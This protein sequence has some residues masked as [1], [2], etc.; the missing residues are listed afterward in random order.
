MNRRLQRGAQVGLLLLAAATPWCEAGALQRLRDGLERRGVE[1]GDWDLDLRG[2][3]LQALAATVQ[4]R[5]LHAAAV[6]VALAGTH[7]RVDVHALSI[8]RAHASDEDEPPP[9]PAPG[10]GAAAT[11]SRDRFRLRPLGLPIE[12]WI[13]DAVAIEAGDGVL[14]LHDV[15][16]DVDAQGWPALSARGDV[17]LPGRLG[18]AIDGL[19]AAR[20][21]GRWDVRAQVLPEGGA[22][23]SVTAS[24][25][26]GGAE[27]TLTDAAGHWLQ[28]RHDP[29]ARTVAM[30]GESFPLAAVGAPQWATQAGVTL[31]AGLRLGD[32]RI[33]GGLELG[34]APPLRV[35]AEALQLEGLVFDD[36]RLAP[37]EVRLQSLTLDGDA[38]LHGP[39][40]A[41]LQLLLAHGPARVAVGARVAD[42][43][44]ELELELAEL[45]CQELLQALPPGVGDAL[46]G[47]RLSGT[48]AASLSLSMS[49]TSL[50][51]A[52]ADGIEPGDAA[53]GGLALS[54][55]F[56]E[57]CRTLADPSDVDLAA[58]RGPYRHRFVAADG[59]VH[60]R[61]LAPGAPEYAP[62][63]SV[64]KIASAFIALEDTHYWYHDGFDREQIERAFWLNV[65]SG[66]VRRGASTISQQAARNLWLGV[67]RSFAR[68]LQEAYLTARLE[69]EVGKARILELYLNLI[70]LGPG[71]HGVDAAARYHFGKPARELDA[72]QAVHL[73]ALAPAPATLS[74]RFA[75]GEVDAAWLEGL[76][77]HLRRMHRKRMI[78]ASEL[79]RALH[80]ELGLVPHPAN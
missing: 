63:A 44:L 17:R 1:V 20:S 12:V 6:D 25:D 64:H 67:D 78:S 42:D 70:E 47:A 3:H 34:T 23:L 65:A 27:A 55:P 30:T 60:D 19:V 28:L 9:A 80:A 53:P 4:G 18:A 54:F 10:A 68:K 51:Q 40:H 36:R 75:S 22:P 43:E 21:E 61:V 59:T 45:S 49:H 2:L 62:L 8:G 74:R 15:R 72:L 35:H 37:G 39:D 50:A 11:P 33:G 31:P 29:A 24:L 73:A 7:V 14:A 57:R 32:V 16:I 77:A 13:H 52:A 56:L 69:A 5:S 26:D 46:V 48:I 38:E 66:R 58:L 79:A 76:H 71:V 41:S